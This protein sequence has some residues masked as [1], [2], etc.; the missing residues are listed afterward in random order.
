MNAMKANVARLVSALE[1]KN[2]EGDTTEEED[3]PNNAGDAFGGS[4]SKKQKT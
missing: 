3:V 1:R 4:K 2:S